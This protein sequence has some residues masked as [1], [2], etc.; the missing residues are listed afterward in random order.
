[1]QLS[2]YC[3]LIGRHCNP[4]CDPLLIGLGVLSRGLTDSLDTVAL[5]G[6]ESSNLSISRI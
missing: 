1:M 5:G 3:Q 6:A 4:L 2:A